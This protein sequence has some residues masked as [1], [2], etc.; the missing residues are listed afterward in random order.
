MGRDDG[1]DIGR[2]L[3]SRALAHAVARLMP[4]SNAAFLAIALAFVALA[5]VGW[6]ILWERHA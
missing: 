4:V 5:V 1:V 6:K 2:S 3:R